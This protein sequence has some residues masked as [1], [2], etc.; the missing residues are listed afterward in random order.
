MDKIIKS[1][2]VLF[3]LIS[4]FIIG[5][6][7]N[8]LAVEKQKTEKWV[9]DYTVMLTQAT[10]N[11][12]EK[13]ILLKKAITKALDGDAPPCEV[14]RI[15]VGL[16]Y[17]VYFAIRYIYE[18]SSEVKL[19]ELCWCATSDGV[20]K[21]IISKAA[22]DARTPDNDPV[23]RQNEIAKS[24]CLRE[25]LAYTAALNSPDPIIPPPPPPPN[26][27]SPITP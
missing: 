27:K 20:E 12:A 22:A 8:C 5:I 25:G 6:A 2:L 19:D 10:N 21:H 1:R 15:A 16:D 18:Y 23:F 14:M 3:V 24:E 13:N 9:T 17:K 11:E 4:I 26:P 7:P